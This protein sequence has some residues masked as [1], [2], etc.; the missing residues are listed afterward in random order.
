MNPTLI[1][2]SYIR[3]SLE[4]QKLVGEVNR[5]LGYHR[6]RRDILTWAKSKRRFIR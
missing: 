1:N 5:K 2:F 6:S 4:E 3:D